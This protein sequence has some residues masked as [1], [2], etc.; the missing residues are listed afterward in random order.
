MFRDK[1]RCLKN[2]DFIK[3]KQYLFNHQSIKDTIM[4]KMFL[5][6]VTLFVLTACNETKK[7]ENENL[8]S[9]TSTMDMEVHDEGHDNHSLE[10]DGLGNDWTSEMKTDNG[11]KWSANPETNEGVQKMQS[12]IK[13]ATTESI[14]DYHQLSE[15]LNAEKNYIVKNCTMKGASHD[16]L[17]VWLLPLM[18]K[19]EALSETTSLDEA[20]KIKHSISENVNAYDDYFE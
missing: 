7:S 11:T 19:I 3:K 4:K 13:T 6:L 2:L 5:S 20:S 17:H 8:N 1:F 12:L 14:A 9:E 18:A 10:G 16:N 15:K